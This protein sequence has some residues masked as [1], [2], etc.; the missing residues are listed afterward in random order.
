MYLTVCPLG[1]MSSIMSLNAVCHEGF[2]SVF[3]GC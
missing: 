3:S 1:G 2:A